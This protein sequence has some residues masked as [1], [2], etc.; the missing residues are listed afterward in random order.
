M[1]GHGYFKMKRVTS[2]RVVGR[3]K[4]SLERML[5]IGKYLTTR[6]KGIQ[7]RMLHSLA[8]MH[9]RKEELELTFCIFSTPP[10]AGFLSD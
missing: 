8:R 5:P 1:Q 10:R 3:D 7:R 6:T 2:S 9:A 4:K